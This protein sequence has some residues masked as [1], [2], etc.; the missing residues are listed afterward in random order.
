MIEPVLKSYMQQVRDAILY[1]PV[2]RRS[3]YMG[4]F[5]A[6]VNATGRLANSLGYEV[7][8]FGGYVYCSDKIDYVLYGR[9]PGKK[10][11]IQPLAEWVR[12]KGLQISPYAVSENIG[13][14]GTTIWQRWQGEESN[15]LEDVNIEEELKTAAQAILSDLEVKLLAA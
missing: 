15:L 6:P 13:R 5:A 9:P 7:T 3:R 12:A 10:P 8:E 2:E 1:K 4:T 11:P 14:F